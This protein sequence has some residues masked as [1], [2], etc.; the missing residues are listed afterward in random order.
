MSPISITTNENRTES[1]HC[2]LTSTYFLDGFS[3]RLLFQSLHPPHVQDNTSIDTKGEKWMWNKFLLFMAGCSK[4][5]FSSRSKRIWFRPW[6]SWFYFLHSNSD[7]ARTWHAAF[8]PLIAFRTWKIQSLFMRDCGIAKSWY[9][10][11]LP[12]CWQAILYSS[13]NQREQSWLILGQKELPTHDSTAASAR[14][15]ASGTTS[16]TSSKSSS[17]LAQSSWARFHW[18]FSSPTHPK[19]LISPKVQRHWLGKPVW[20]QPHIPDRFAISRTFCHRHVHL[21]FSYMQQ[22]EKNIRN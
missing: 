17:E 19:T 16:I 3:S 4:H 12:F 9:V 18:T 8:K 7:L 22:M 6:D 21:C 14:I 1:D 20:Y 2:S 10:S 5:Y 11:E 15:H 13:L